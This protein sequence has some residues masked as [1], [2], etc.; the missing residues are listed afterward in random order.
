M[1]LCYCSRGCFSRGVTTRTISYIQKTAV[2]S[3][4][5]VAEQPDHTASLMRLRVPV[6]RILIVAVRHFPASTGETLKE[7][8]S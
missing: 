3:L 8:V 6:T 5:D 4:P 2:P 7:G 1:C